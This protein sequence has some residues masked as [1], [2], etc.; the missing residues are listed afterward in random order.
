MIEEYSPGVVGEIHTDYVDLDYEMTKPDYTAIDPDTIPPMQQLTQPQVERLK[1]SHLPPVPVF[2]AERQFVRHLPDEP[3][4]IPFDVRSFGKPKHSKT[5]HQNLSIPSTAQSYSLCIEYAKR[6]FLGLFEKHPFKSIYVDGKNVFDDYRRLASVELLKR[7]KPALAIM[8]SFDWSFNNDNVDLYQFGTK[9]YR[10]AGNYQNSFYRDP[11]HASYLGIMMETLFME[12]TFR[13][14]L[15][16]RAQQLDM[17]N[18]LKL[19]GRVGNTIGEDVDLD[20]HIPYD[21]ILSLAADAGF[22]IC[23]PETPSPVD[24]PRVKNVKAFLAHLNSH[25]DIPFLYKMRAINGRNEYFLR[26]HNMYVHVRPTGVNGDDGEREGVLNNNFTVEL[27][28]EIRFPVPKFYAYYTDNKRDFTTVYSAWRQPNGIVSAFY[29]FKGIQVPNKNKRGWDKYL[30]T[31]YED[32]IKNIGKHLDIDLSSLLSERELGETIRHCIHTGI[33]PSI[34]VDTVVI[35]GGEYMGGR[36]DWDTLHFIG[37]TDARSQNSYLAIYVDLMFINEY[38]ANA[39]E[40]D[41][42]RLQHT[43]DPADPYKD[44]SPSI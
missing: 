12:F 24:Y 20:F 32:D 35:N 7:E 14:R 25:S 18:Y 6:W 41:E 27:T 2:G 40:A 43:K 31:S 15:E 19:A 42:N 11:N 39:R 26:M 36:I 9:L 23:A 4:M 3:E 21:I 1:A 30:E 38:I 29:T 17:Y 33:S 22:E 44:S 28:A 34:F 16:T 8:P 37:D 5:L 13:I 10:S